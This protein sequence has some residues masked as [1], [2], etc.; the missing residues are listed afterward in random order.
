MKLKGWG[1]RFGSVVV[2]VGAA[3]VVLITGAAAQAQHATHTRGPQP[4][5]GGEPTPVP[6]S[7][8]VLS[9]PKDMYLHPGA[10]T[11]W[12]WSIGT[13]RSGSRLFG[14]EI[15]AASFISRG[16]A[17]SQISLTDVKNN[18]HYERTTPYVS[19]TPFNGSTWAQSNPN[20]NWYARLGSPTQQLS[21]VQVD[22]PAAATRAPA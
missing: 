12:W 13:L 14:F 9:L 2:V 6:P 22:K 20:K 17:F 11:E 3:V 4:A 15:N 8:V 19:G 5:T 21:G 10:P 18:R 7:K 16:F 1:L